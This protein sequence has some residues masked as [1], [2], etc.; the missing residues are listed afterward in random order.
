[1]GGALTN[2]IAALVAAVLALALLSD[3]PASAGASPEPEATDLSGRW[4]LNKD[5][6]DDP[7]KALEATHHQ[8][9]DSV[10][11]GGSGGH[12]PGHGAGSMPPGGFGGHG[13]GHGG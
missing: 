8:G 3:T 2:R 1:M 9:H 7:A 13:P 10:P 6:S 4:I 11:T 5:L 12:G